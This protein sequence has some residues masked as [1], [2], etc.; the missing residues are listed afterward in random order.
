MNMCIPTAQN[1]PSYKTCPIGYMLCPNDACVLNL[2]EC[3]VSVEQSKMIRCWD[4]TYV[5]TAGNCPTKVSCPNNYIT[6]PDNTCAKMLSNCKLLP[7]C[8]GFE[9]RCPDGTCTSTTCPIGKTCPASR[10]ILCPNQACVD[11]ISS[12]ID[13]TCPYEKPYHCPTGECRSRYEDCSTPIAC[14]AGN[15]RCEDGTCVD[16]LTKCSTYSQGNSCP[17]QNVR[18]P[19]GSCVQSLSHCP[20]IVTCPKNSYRCSDGTCIGNA[21]QCPT[22]ERVAC[23]AGTYACPIVNRDTNICVDD[24]AKCPTEIICPVSKP[25]RC[26]DQSCA[27]SIE[28]CPP[29]INTT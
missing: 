8:K 28:A 27:T 7:Q 18:C 24:L 9:K 3:V 15:Q 23:K 12:C 13:N 19:N 6:C 17:S 16:N 21:S 26:Y 25:V 4:G 5:S 22:T 1:C 14:A 20:T 11:D 10:P 29:V 2:S